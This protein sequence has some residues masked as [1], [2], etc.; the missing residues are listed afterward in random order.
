MQVDFEERHF[1]ARL[2]QHAEA[3]RHGLQ[4]RAG[5][6][7]GKLPPCS[8]SVAL[9]APMAL[10]GS[11]L[12]SVLM[13]IQIGLGGQLRHGWLFLWDSARRLPQE[14]YWLPANSLVIPS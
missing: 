8:H 5:E 14:A 3:R 6:E 9:A 1:A 7:G 2:P 13:G 10:R 11:K 4:G 12:P